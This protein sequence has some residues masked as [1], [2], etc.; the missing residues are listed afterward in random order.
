M[1]RFRQVLALTLSE[2]R[3][4]LV[5]LFIF[6]AVIFWRAKQAPEK[7]SPQLNQSSQS[8]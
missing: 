2:Q 1:K 5:L 4:V 6:V 7:L 3:V 8:R